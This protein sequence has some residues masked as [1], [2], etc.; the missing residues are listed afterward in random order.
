M[1]FYQ[2]S[3]V[4]DDKRWKGEGDHGTKF[5]DHTPDPVLHRAFCVT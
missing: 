4:I 3:L 1:I 5:V 2:F